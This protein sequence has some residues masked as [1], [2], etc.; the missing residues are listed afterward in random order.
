[1]QEFGYPF[2]AGCVLLAVIHTN[3]DKLSNQMWWWWSGYETLFGLNLDI[4]KYLTL[5]FFFSVRELSDQEER[6]HNGDAS[7][8]LLQTLFV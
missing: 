1:M 3:K 8:S 2:V 4:T 7:C 5:G 6:R